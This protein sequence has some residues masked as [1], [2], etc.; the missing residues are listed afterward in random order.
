MLYTVTRRGGRVRPS[1]KRLSPFLTSCSVS[2]DMRLRARGRN[3][4][5]CGAR[6]KG[7][8]LWTS[9]SWAQLDQLM[10][11]ALPPENP[12]NS[13]LNQNL[14]LNPVVCPAVKQYHFSAP[15]ILYKG[16]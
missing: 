9:A 16:N 13:T 8:A 11:A 10:S 1:S 3:F 12:H 4:A 2:E 15:Y 7:S 6:P 14:S 5:L